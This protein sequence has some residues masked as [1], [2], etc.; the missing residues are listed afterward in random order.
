MGKWTHAICRPCYE[1]LEPGREPIE[2]LSSPK[3][4][5]CWCNQPTTIYY[6]A[7]PASVPCQGTGPIHAS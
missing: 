2:V 7:D 3:D 5:C 6:R 4:R 1:K